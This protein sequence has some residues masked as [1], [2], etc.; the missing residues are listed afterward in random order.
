MK[1]KQFNI[2]KDHK[3]YP[4]IWLAGHE[5]KLHVYIWEQVNGSKPKGYDIHHINHN[6]ENY[7]IDNL[8]LLTKS[9]H[10]RHHAGWIQKNNTWYKPCSKCKQVKPINEY[11]YVKTIKL[12]H[13]YCKICFNK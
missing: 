8:Q 9:D 3:D 4:C 7:T 2:Y 5:V 10:K 13:R 1:Y 12:Y 6:K 11:Y